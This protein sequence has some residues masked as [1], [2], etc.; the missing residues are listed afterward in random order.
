MCWIVFLYPSFCT[1]QEWR[2]FASFATLKSG[3]DSFGWIEAVAV[4]MTCNHLD[5]AYLKFSDMF[6]NFLP[7]LEAVGES[8]MA[9]EKREDEAPFYYTHDVGL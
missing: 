7:G 6:P 3:P 1:P 8:R 9:D 2:K 4:V 5:F